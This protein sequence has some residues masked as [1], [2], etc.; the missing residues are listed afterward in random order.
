MTGKVEVDEAYFGGKGRNKHDDKK[1][2]GGRWVNRL[3]WA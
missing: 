3:W 1:N 2:G